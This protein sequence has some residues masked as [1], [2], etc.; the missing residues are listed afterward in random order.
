MQSPVPAEAVCCTQESIR[1]N[2]E[3]LAEQTYDRLLE[4]ESLTAGWSDC[5]KGGE[6]L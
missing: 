3:L 6:E 4:K 5:Y 2:L 1:A